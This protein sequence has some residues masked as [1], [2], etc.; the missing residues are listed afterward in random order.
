[1]ENN[2]CDIRCYVIRLAHN[3]LYNLVGRKKPKKV[4]DTYKRYCSIKRNIWNLVD[5]NRKKAVWYKK[6][7]EEGRKWRTFVIEAKHLMCQASG[8]N[9]HRHL[10]ATCP[11]TYILDVVSWLYKP[12]VRHDLHLFGRPNLEFNIVRVII[13]TNFRKKGKN[14]HTRKRNK[15]NGNITPSS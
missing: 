9:L 3:K 15:P 6:N 11:V 14:E 12:N 5:E 13:M 7:D 2:M 10:H 4:N 8:I 1:M